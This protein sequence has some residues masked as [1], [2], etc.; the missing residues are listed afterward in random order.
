MWETRK[1]LK[2]NFIDTLATVRKG[3]W[4]GK[5]EWR[6]EKASIRGGTQGLLH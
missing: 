5:L 6:S 3:S 2:E 1:G 4:G